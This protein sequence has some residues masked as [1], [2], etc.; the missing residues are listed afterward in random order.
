M[1]ARLKVER[2][3]KS[4]VRQSNTSS[5]QIGPTLR[6]GPMSYHVYIANPGFRETPIPRDAW[7]KAARECDDVVVEEKKNRF[8]KTSY[9]VTLKGGDKRAWLDLD[10]HGLVMSQDPSREL[11]IVMFKLA[12]ALGADVYSERLKKYRSIDDW[13]RRT[14]KYRQSR[15]KGR[16]Q[17][18]S[19]RRRRILLWLLYLAACLALGW[20][21][22]GR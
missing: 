20:F 4:V 5:R 7:L 8:G 3:E 18:L 13:E 21:L 12:H 16:A 15:D 17:Y 14:R 9:S 22:G 1:K 11:V 2:R 19:D 10:P 6:Y